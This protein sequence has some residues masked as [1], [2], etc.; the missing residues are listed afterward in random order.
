MYNALLDKKIKNERVQ[1]KKMKKNQN[2]KSLK[3]VLFVYF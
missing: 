3:N 2:L 1:D